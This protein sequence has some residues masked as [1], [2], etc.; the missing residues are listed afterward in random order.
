MSV[1]W[2]GRQR[3]LCLSQVGFESMVPLVTAKGINGS[4]IEACSDHH[5]F[6]KLFPASDARQTRKARACFDAMQRYLFSASQ[7]RVRTSDSLCLH[8]NLFGMVLELLLGEFCMTPSVSAF[9]IACDRQSFVCIWCA[10]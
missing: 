7:T 9:V 6:A 5:A 2:I 4:D 10:M 1:H 8:V 3:L